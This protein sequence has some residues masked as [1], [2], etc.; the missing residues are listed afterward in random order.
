MPSNKYVSNEWSKS[1]GNDTN[2][3]S[4][5]FH[6]FELTKAKNYLNSISW[7]ERKKKIVVLTEEDTFFFASRYFQFWGYH[8]YIIKSNNGSLPLASGINAFHLAAHWYKKEKNSFEEM[9][10]KD[11]FFKCNKRVFFRMLY[12][13]RSAYIPVSNLR[14]KLRK[15]LFS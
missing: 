5:Y 7:R 8:S 10:T 1:I 13:L 12:W 3:K 11:I 14:V 6:I 9:Q 15:I 4:A 2:N